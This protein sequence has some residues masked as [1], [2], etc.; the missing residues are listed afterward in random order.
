MKIDLYKRI[1]NHLGFVEI[2]WFLNIHFSWL[3]RLIQKSNLSPKDCFQ[4]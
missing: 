2:N 4:D 3:T 1:I